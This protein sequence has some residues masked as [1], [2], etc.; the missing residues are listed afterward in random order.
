VRPLN[1][2]VDLDE[3]RSVL[4]YDPLTGEFRW[5]AP[6]PKAWR[7]RAGTVHR[8]GYRY[9]NFGGL[10]HAEH[11]LAWLYVHGAWPSTLHLDHIDGDT[12]NNRLCNLRE[13]T[14]IQN[15][16]NQ[17][18]AKN[19]TSGF[20]GVYLVRRPKHADRW[21]AQTMFNGRFYTFGRY[22]TPEEAGRAAEAGRKRLF[23]EFA[24][25]AA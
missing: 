22:K 1:P 4:S 16:G 7:P 13:A 9:L 3:L 18:V 19:N 23:G 5:K 20:R 14:P 17:R 6:H 24:R 2:D 21:L 15:A 8:T 12:Q 10:A 25:E 11:R